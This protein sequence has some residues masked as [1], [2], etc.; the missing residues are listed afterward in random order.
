MLAFLPSAIIMSYPWAPS[1]EPRMRHF[2][3]TALALLMMAALKVGVARAVRDT[4]SG[5]EEPG[6]RGRDDY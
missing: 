6:W 1:R 4:S 3:L 2:F 5:S